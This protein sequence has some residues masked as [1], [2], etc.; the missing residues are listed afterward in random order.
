MS[1]VD[2]IA[3]AQGSIG[4]VST[5]A[6]GESRSRSLD[7]AR[8]Q[9]IEAPTAPEV[10]ALAIT[11]RH[12]LG[13]QIIIKQRDATATITFYRADSSIY[14]NGSVTWNSATG[15]FIGFSEIP[16]LCGSIDTRVTT[17]TGGLELFMESSG[18]LRM[19]TNRKRNQLQPKPVDPDMG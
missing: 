5:F 11:Y 16:Y 7:S 15:G 2:Q 12:P 1:R 6:S 19:R 3:D 17:I 4:I 14:G 18:T 13:A 8:R 10:P 9:S